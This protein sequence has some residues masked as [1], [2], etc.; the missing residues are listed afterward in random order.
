VAGVFSGTSVFGPGEAAETSLASEG[1]FDVYY[2]KLDGSGAVTWMRSFGGAGRD[3]TC[4][5]TPVGAG[6]VIVAGSFNDTLTFGAGTPSE[7]QLEEAAP[8]E[9][10]DGFLARL[11][12][13]G[14][15]I[16]AQSIAG[17]GEMGI[18]GAAPLTDDRVVV[19]GYYQIGVTFDPG[20]PS[21]VSFAT[22]VDLQQDIFLAAYS[23]DGALLWVR[24]IRSAGGGSVDINAA[25]R[26]AALPEGGFLLAGQFTGPITFDDGGPNETTFEYTGYRS[27]F[28]AK[29]TAAGDLSWVKAAATGIDRVSALA[30]APDGAFVLGGWYSGEAL[31]GDWEPAET[32]LP[33]ADGQWNA[34]LALHAADGALEWAKWVGSSGF[35]DFLYGAALFAD[36]DVA[37]AG[38]FTGSATFGD[39]EPGETT[40]FADYSAAD[41]WIARFDGTDG[42]LE[43]V[44]AV[45]GDSEYD[46]MAG[47]LDTTA[48]GDLVVGG[49]FGGTALLG[50]GDPAETSLVCAGVMDAFFARYAF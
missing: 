9:W 7:L 5:F 42:H 40:L 45:A 10:H 1:D 16:W 31:F 32:E 21:E 17:S 13:D 35:D 11:G 25:T 50:E 19:T 6:D 27:A 37:A 8:D 26:V 3:S 12:G 4:A 48:S 14:D 22:E 20:G 28:A 18:T 41:G 15:P 47:W 38:L 29:Y 43:D 44:A 49:G 36:G 30:V 23:D 2:G 39:G 46:D 33:G 24:R 34:F